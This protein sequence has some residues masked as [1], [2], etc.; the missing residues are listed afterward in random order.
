MKILPFNLASRAVCRAC[1]FREVGVHE[2]HARLDGQWR[3]VII[4]ERVIVENT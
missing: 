2:K 4:V 3:N 1:G